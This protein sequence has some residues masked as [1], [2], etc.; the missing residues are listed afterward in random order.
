MCRS[1]TPRELG[2]FSAYL[3]L[4]LEWNRVYSLTGYREPATI[5]Q[6]LFLDSLLFLRLIPPQTLRLLD[7]GSG[8]GI[9]GI[10]L[11][12]IEPALSLTL[13][14]ARRRRTSFL[15]AVVRKLALE[16]VQVLLGR[17]ES[18]IEADPSLEGQFDAVVTRAAGPVERVTPLALRFLKRGGRFVA[19][20]PPMTKRAGGSTTGGSW[21]VVTIPVTG[22]RRRFL[23]VEKN[24]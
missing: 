9:P 10:P 16:R 19:S 5:V 6:K 3:A 14:E 7:I 2:A 24:L 8:A 4:L 12:I 23:V 21:Q 22:L 20:G 17:A 11:K 13:I 18:L 15:T 1:P